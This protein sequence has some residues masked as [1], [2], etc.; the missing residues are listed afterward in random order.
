MHWKRSVFLL[1]VFGLLTAGT[2]SSLIFPNS[3]QAAVD[4]Y[5]SPV[6]AGCYLAKLDRCKIHVEPFTINLASGEKLV[7]F[8]LVANRVG[9]NWQVIY[10]FQPDASNQPPYGGATTYTPTLVKRDFA[11]SCGASYSVRLQGQGTVGPFSILGTTNQFT[12]P[13]GTF[14]QYMPSIRR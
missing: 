9:G 11:A 7:R 14:M 4:I 3:V 10:D 1:V 8:Q 2:G 6:N 13:K 5:A 12:C